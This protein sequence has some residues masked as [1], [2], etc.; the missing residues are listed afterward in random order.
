MR[1]HGRMASR[2][3]CWLEAMLNRL[4]VV[5]KLSKRHE[6]AFDCSPRRP[7]NFCI[8]RTVMMAVRACVGAPWSNPLAELKSKNMAAMREV[9]RSMERQILSPIQHG[10]IS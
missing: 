8:A 6:C 3:R 2:R 10:R 7:C 4:Q 9:H 1:K 5:R